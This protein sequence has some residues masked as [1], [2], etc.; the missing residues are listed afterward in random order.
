MNSKIKVAIAEG[1]PGAKECFATFIEPLESFEIVGFADNG[2]SLLDLN[3][4]LKPDIIIADMNMTLIIGKEA[5]AACLVVNPHLKFIFTS[6]HSEYAVHAF[7]LN[8]V[9]YVIKPIK[10]ERLYIALEKAKMAISKQ[11]LAGKKKI[12]TLQIN[13]DS[14]FIHFSKI[15][16]IEKANRKTIVHTLD[17]KYETNE[18]LDS[19][20][21]RLNSDFFR[22]HRA[23][24]VNLYY[25]SQITTEGEGYL[26][27]LEDHP[28]FVHISKLRIKELYKEI[29]FI[30]GE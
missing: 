21:K 28:H 19:I 15:I 23:F 13:R 9:D 7:D 5:I 30:S 29:S 3:S 17:K 18:S 11:N 4:K 12:L 8:A 16:Y 2:E 6:A 20:S 10:K 24:I 26:A 27:Y 25:I 1:H 22:T 14:H